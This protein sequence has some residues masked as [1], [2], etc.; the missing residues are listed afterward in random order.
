VTADIIQTL[1]DSFRF[2]EWNARRGVEQDCRCAYCERDL[3]ASYND[4]NSWQFDHVYPMSQG[5][6]HSFENI[7]VCCKACN[8]LKLT[9]VPDGTTHQERIADA[10]RYVLARRAEMEAEIDQVRLL[11]RG[12]PKA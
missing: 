2:G 12:T 5:G 6:E 10:R 8:Y 4:Y 7:V 11:V 9:Y 3:L 1:Q